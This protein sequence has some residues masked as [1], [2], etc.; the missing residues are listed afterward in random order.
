M[1][2]TKRRRITPKGLLEQMAGRRIDPNILPASHK[3][4]ILEYLLVCPASELND[5]Q[6]SDCPNF[7]YESAKLLIDSRLPEYMNML[8]ICRAM[9]QEDSI[10]EQKK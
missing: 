5:Y 2:E 4:V 8:S 10:K 9:A 1:A 6:T 7:I 3:V